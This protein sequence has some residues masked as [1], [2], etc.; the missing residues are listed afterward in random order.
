MK[1]TMWVYNNKLEENLSVD[2][3]KRY[4]REIHQI[5]FGESAGNEH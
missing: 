1:F 4:P 5:D 2:N 3:L